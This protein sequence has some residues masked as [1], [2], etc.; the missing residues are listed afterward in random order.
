MEGFIAEPIG[1]KMHRDEDLRLE[2]F[3]GTEGFFRIHMVFP[4]FRTVIGPD[5]EEGDFG[6]KFF[7][8]FAETRKVTRVA[9]VVNGAAAHID[10]ISAISTMVIG[11][12]SGAPVF[13]GHKGDG[14]PRKPE[15]FPPLHFIDF[16]KSEPVHEIPNSG[17]N[18]NGLVGGDSAQATPVEV[19]EVGVGDENQID[20]GEVMVGKSGMAQS[21]DHKKPVRPVRVDQNVPLMALDEEGCVTDPRDADLALAEFWENGGRSVPMAAFSGK[22]GGQKNIGDKT[23]GGP[24][25]SFSCPCTQGVK[26]DAKKMRR[27]PCRRDWLHLMIQA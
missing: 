12:F 14:R 25:G 2:I 1:P 23:M 15:P 20:R 18:D 7:S 21:T 3:K 8:D 19:V 11:D 10:H 16:F 26:N 13:G 4:E 6:V 27:Q 22:K 5:R 17:W 24:S 9:R